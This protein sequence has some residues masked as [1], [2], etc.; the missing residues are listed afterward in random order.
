MEHNVVIFAN[1]N[2]LESLETL[3]RRTDATLF[4]VP[5][6]LV[7]S[8]GLPAVTEAVRNAKP[9]AQVLYDHGGAGV[10]AP[11]TAEAFAACIEEAGVDYPLLRPAGGSY[12]LTAYTKALDTVDATPVISCVLTFAVDDVVLS[13]MEHDD[14]WMGDGSDHAIFDFAYACGCRH[15]EV[16]MQYPDIAKHLMDYV[17]EKY[18]AE[19]R[20]E[21]T[22]WVFNRRPTEH[23]LEKVEETWGPGCVNFV[24]DPPSGRSG[25]STPPGGGVPQPR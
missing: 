23:T 7:M 8:V 2:T 1:C 12:T 22:L 24:L 5:S 10:D 21:L 3:V 9:T 16:P 14:G 19:Q 20:A 25:R 6:D 18:S 15:F 13:W 11:E 4:Q 17:M